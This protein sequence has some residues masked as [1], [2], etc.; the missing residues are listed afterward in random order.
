MYHG[1][2]AYIGRRLSAGQLHGC[3]CVHEATNS[4]DSDYPTATLPDKEYKGTHGSSTPL[5][6]P[7]TLFSSN[8]W[9]KIVRILFS[10]NW[11]AR[12][13]RMYVRHIFRF[14]SSGEFVPGVV[15]LE[16]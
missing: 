9:P 14:S 8:F 12:L 15:T 5:L 2:N 7:P 3:L 10:A 4:D 1:P 6:F 16:N 11:Y 13:L